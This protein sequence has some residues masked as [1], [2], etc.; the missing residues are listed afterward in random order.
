MFGDAGG[1]GGHG[2]YVHSGTVIVAGTGQEIRGGNGAAGDFSSSIPCA[3]DGPP[4]FGIFVE[5]AAMCT[6]SG[7]APMGGS[8]TGPPAC[9]TYFAPGVSAN[10]AMAA[11]ADPSL[12]VS[13]ST[14]AGSIVTFDLHAAPGSTARLD[15]GRSPIAIADGL[16]LI[17]DLAPAARSV[18]LGLV[19][20][21]GTR[22]V[23]WR[24]PANLPV[25]TFLVLQAEV[26]PPSG[27]L[28]RTNSVP[29]VVR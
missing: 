18:N 16:A 1:S 8:S 21:S 23:S 25:G 6:W 26:T 22:S 29:I 27:V 24:I 12:D 19:P 20:P 4:G 14:A 13:G 5:P 15:L 10:A 11:P 9:A 7:V 3:V 2:W 17:E 28:A